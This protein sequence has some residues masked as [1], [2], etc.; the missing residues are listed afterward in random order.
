M[1]IGVVGTGNMGRSLGLLFAEQG[2]EVFFGARDLAKAQAA[3]ALAAGGAS[4][5]SNDEAARH[6]EVLVWGIRDVPPGEVLSD[7]GVLAGKILIDMNNGEVRGDG[8]AGPV[9]ESLAER[10]QVAAPGASVVK[11]FNTLPMEV[12]D[13]APEPLRRYGVSV[14]VATDDER[15]GRTVS[16]L[17]ASIG[18]VPVAFGTL[19]YA[20]TLEAL[21]DVTR[22]LIMDMGHPA[23]ATVSTQDLPAPEQKR[24][25]GRQASE[26]R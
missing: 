10:L 21:G 4:F 2:H 18:F 5:G 15:A 17:A 13:L 25:G 22:H 19:R 26:L 14:F 24:L 6:G 16:E 9:G 23:T 8:G 1:K 7:L 12:F 20:R 3:A 11:A